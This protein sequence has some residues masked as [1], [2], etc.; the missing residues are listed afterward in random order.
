MNASLSRDECAGMIALIDSAGE[1][2][3]RQRIALIDLFVERAQSLEFTMKIVKQEIARVKTARPE[4]GG[5]AVFEWLARHGQ[6]AIILDSVKLDEAVKSRDLLVPY[7]SALM[8]S[9][10]WQEMEKIL[11]MKNLPI[12]PVDRKLFAAYQSHGR[13]E[14]AENTRSRLRSALSQAATTKQPSVM[15]Q[16]L[17]AA[18]SLGEHD[19]AIEAAESLAAIRP[20]Q[21]PMLLRIYSLRQEKADLRGM[22]AAADRILRIRPSLPPYQ[23][24]ASYLRLI[25]GFDLEPVIGEFSKQS[26]PASPSQQHLLNLALAAWHCGD[27]DGALD[28]LKAL[29]AGQLSRGPR[30]VHA[31]LLRFLGKTAEAFQ[32]AEGIHETGI[33]PE[34]KFFLQAARQ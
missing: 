30:A 20:L 11:A 4:D 32:A 18:A 8:Q 23:D 5:G 2:T 25:S 24:T 29:N 7:A 27:T 19:L 34:E 10:R 28:F 9:G 15:Q 33:F 12:S 13:N 26:V 16:V 21:L 6:G 1:M 22:M 14:P 17:N 3:E 31:G